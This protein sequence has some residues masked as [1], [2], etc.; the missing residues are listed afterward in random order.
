MAESQGVIRRAEAPAWGAERV[1]A[2][3]ELAAVVVGVGNP[4]FAK[5]LVVREI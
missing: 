5:F 4:A 3:E 1:A 2:E